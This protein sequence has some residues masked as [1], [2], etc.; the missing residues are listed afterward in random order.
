M[1][2]GARS[3]LLLLAR[4]AIH[5]QRQ[6]AR[7]ELIELLWPGVAIDAGRN[8]L[9]QTL[10]S[11]RQILEPIGAASG[12]VLDADRFG[13]R[14][15]PGRLES[16]V[17]RF[18]AAL[19]EGRAA[20]A[21]AL[22]G[23]ELLPGFYDDWVVQERHAPRGAARS[24]PQEAV[25]AGG[26]PPA[27]REGAGD[28][29]TAATAR[30][31]TRLV[32]SAGRS[33]LPTLPDALLRPRERA[34]R[35]ARSRC[36]THR[37]VTLLGAGGSGKT[38]L[39][40]ELRRR[41]CRRRRSRGFRRWSPF[42]PLVRL[43]DA[44]ATC[45]PRLRGDAAACMR[46]TKI[47]FGA[48]VA[49][50][51][52]DGVRC[53]CSTTSS[54]CCGDGAW[55]GR[56]SSPRRCPSLHLLVT[57]RRALGVDGE[58]ELRDRRARAAAPRRRRSRSPRSGPPSALFVDR[59]RG[60][61]ADFAG[62]VRATSARSSISCTCS[63]ACRWRSSSQPRACAAST[64]AT[65]GRAAACGPRRRRRAAPRCRCW[66]AAGRARGTDPRHASMQR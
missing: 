58:R 9:R 31:R 63:K 14:V 34:Q 17:T 38:R 59:A 62:R 40:V 30:E 15:V 36:S 53:S 48:L 60:A 55:R 64:P 43:R 44:R 65:D 45:S 18:E 13:V 52:P 35:A 33:R 28:G 56:R 54:S 3:V 46:P 2:F 4:L 5:P 7:E 6:H 1:Q 25:A 41:A 12:P 11:L 50:A 29:A 10:F 37:L 27:A 39:A 24:A 49:G 16:D 66:R 22:Y 8:R 21:L 20:A 42:A 61:R 26:D 51:R 23:G 32:A 19:R 47:S 57:S